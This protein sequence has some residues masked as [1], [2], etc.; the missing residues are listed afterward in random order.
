MSVLTAALSGMSA[1]REQL[2]LAAEGIRR[3][4]SPRVSGEPRQVQ[5]DRVELSEAAVRLLAARTA[6]KAAVELAR[7]ADE[8]DREAIGLLG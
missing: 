1:A 4:T 5:G 6:F 7:T 3:A 2:D 8:I